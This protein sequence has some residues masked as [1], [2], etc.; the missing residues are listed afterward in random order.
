MTI[1]KIDEYVPDYTKRC[2]NCGQTPVVTAVKN[3]KVVL[4][5][6]MCGPCT[7]GDSVSIDPN[8]WNKE[9]K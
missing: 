1:L 8:E 2:C 6:E 4:D 5:T 9:T 7:W 3:S